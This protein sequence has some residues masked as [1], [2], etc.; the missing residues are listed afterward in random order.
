MP[1]FGCLPYSAITSNGA[2]NASDCYGMDGWRSDE[3]MPQICLRLIQSTII[4]KP[5]ARTPKEIRTTNG[6]LTQLFH[7]DFGVLSVFGFREFGFED[8]AL[9]CALVF[10]PT[11]L[12]SH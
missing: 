12:F 3:G 10:A 1:S 9:A 4:R 8:V 7:S 5:R 6:I 11:P 2:A